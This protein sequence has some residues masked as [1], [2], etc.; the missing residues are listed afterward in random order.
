VGWGAE[1][2]QAGAAAGSERLAKY[3]RLLAIEKKTRWPIYKRPPA[4]KTG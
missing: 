3:N 4:T 1:Y 2:L